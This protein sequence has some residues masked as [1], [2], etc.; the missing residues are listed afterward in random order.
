VSSRR[1][2]GF[3]LIELL[4]SVTIAIILL[5]LAMPGYI[6]WTANAEIRNGAE[7]VASGL[8]FTQNVAINRNESAQF[9]LSAT[10]WTVTTVAAPLTIL[11]QAS[12]VEGARNAT[13]VAVDAGTL[14]A[15]TVAFNALGQIVPNGTNVV[16]IDVSSTVAGT[17]PLRVLVGNG[18]TGVKMC[19]P[20]WAWPDPKGCPP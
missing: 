20:S 13:V 10:G 1:H 11:Q 9:V 18:R 3:T 6:A 12:F 7:S 19:D 14:P 4:V 5:V 17:R 16:Q 8:R 2:L 15:T